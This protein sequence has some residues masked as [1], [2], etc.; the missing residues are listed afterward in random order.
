MPLLAARILRLVDE[1]VVDAAVE[2]EQHPVRPLLLV[3]QAHGLGDEIVVVERGAAGLGAACS[4]AARRRRDGCSASVAAT[5][6][7]ALRSSSSATKRAL[8]RAEYGVEIGMLRLDGACSSG[9][10]AASPLPVQK[11]ALERV[12]AGARCARGRAPRRRLPASLRSL[13]PP[14]L[15]ASRRR[16]RSGSRTVSASARVEAVLGGVPAHAECTRGRAS[17]PRRARRRSSSADARRRRRAS[18]A[19]QAPRAAARRSAR[20]PR[21]GWPSAA[22]GPRASAARASRARAPASIASR[23]SEM[24]GRLVEDREA[25]RHARLQRKALQQAL[26]EGVDGLHLEAAGRLDGHREQRARALDLLLRGRARAELGE[27]G[28][29]R[30]VRPWSPTCASVS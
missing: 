16:C 26:A 17:P 2:L 22:L 21:R 1:D 10:R 8:C 12:D 29:E 28:G 20:R 19:P 23:C 11:N 27:R 7:S 4:A 14:A 30:L 24:R 15:S 6:A 3:Q 5:T 18:G 13:A 9:S 25:R